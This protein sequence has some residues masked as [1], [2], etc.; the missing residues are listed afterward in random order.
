MYGVPSSAGTI[1]EPR[2]VFAAAHRIGEHRALAGLVAQLHAHRFEHR[3]Q[4]GE[5]D[6]RI[7]TED[8]LRIERNARGQI[9][10]FEEI[11]TRRACL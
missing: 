3:Q 4:V 10:R 2:H 1:S 9:R 8:A 7:D 5:H 11:E 6:R